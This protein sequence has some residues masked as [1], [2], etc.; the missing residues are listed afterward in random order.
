[1]IQRPERR[2]GRMRIAVRHEFA[3]DAAQHPEALA[4]RHRAHACLPDVVDIAPPHAPDAV[5]AGKVWN[6]W[7]VASRGEGSPSTLPKQISATDHH[8][9]AACP[10]SSS[11][12][13]SAS[14]TATSRDSARPAARASASGRVV[15]LCRVPLDSLG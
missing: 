1:M 5:E 11:E 12:S 3:I 8:L 14:L 2:S 10:A 9:P 4:Y 15:A 6:L 13:A 7:V